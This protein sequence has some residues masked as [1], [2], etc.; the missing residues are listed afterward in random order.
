MHY[1]RF[2]PSPPGKNLIGPRAAEMSDIG[3]R[4]A[5]K[6]LQIPPAFYP[7]ASEVG[8][9]ITG[10][11][12]AKLLGQAM[13]NGDW[14]K[15]NEARRGVNTDLPE[16]GITYNGWVSRHGSIF[17]PG[18]LI[19]AWPD[20]AVSKWPTFVD[21]IMGTDAVQSPACSLACM[22]ACADSISLWC[23]TAH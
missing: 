6:L 14:A 5:Y 7:N 1:L 3:I 9:L 19:E 15:V 11:G 22:H 23:R 4:N 13:I 17:S 16:V 12:F 8:K 21:Q 2:V 20:Q 10:N 18:I